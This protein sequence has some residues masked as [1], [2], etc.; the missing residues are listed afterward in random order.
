MNGIEHALA[1]A[2][3]GLF[4]A[5]R[6]AAPLREQVAEALRRAI[7]EFTFQPGQRLVERELIELTGV[8]RTTVREV[9][10][11]LES[12]GLVR[13]IP[14]RGAVVDA[15]T[16]SEAVELYEVRATLES[17]AV[18]RFIDYASD[19][20][21]SALR[22]AQQRFAAAAREQPDNIRELL[23]AKDEFYE[24]LLQGSGSTAVRDILH[25]LQARVR[26]LRARSLSRPGRPTESAAELENLVEAIEVGDHAAADAVCRRHLSNASESGDE[27]VKLVEN[28]A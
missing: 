22:D 2:L 19:A 14:Q 11:N 4:N 23:R 15:P 24:V 12:E 7:L 1:P 16:P 8:S 25:R 21:K 10:R 28:E 5:Q 27:M 13:L 20:T 17:L 9:L 18:N 26:F 3:P 6:V